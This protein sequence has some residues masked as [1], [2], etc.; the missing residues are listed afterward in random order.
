MHLLKT[1]SNAH[2][3]EL[4]SLTSENPSARDLNDVL[5]IM[6]DVALRV[7]QLR[8][9]RWADVD[10][11][12]RMLAITT[13][14]SGVRLVSVSAKSIR[15]LERRRERE[16]ESEYVLGIARHALLDRVTRQLAF[17]FIYLGL[18]RLSLHMV[19]RAFA[20]RVLAPAGA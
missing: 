7:E 5:Q 10:V 11:S 19:C 9:L 8:D 20:A 17:H 15:V 16:P 18:G 1:L 12:L 2:L 3:D 6:S 14:A 13:R 4:L